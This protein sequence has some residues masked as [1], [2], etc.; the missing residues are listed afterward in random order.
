MQILLMI[1]V[2]FLRWIVILIS[3][4]ASASFVALNLRSYVETND[5]TVV[6]LAAFLLQMAL[7]IFIK[8]W[9]FP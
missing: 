2:E 9:F 4:A 1:P 6:L 5:V 3:G 8:M 7:A